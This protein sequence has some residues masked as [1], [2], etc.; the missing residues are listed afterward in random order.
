[1]TKSTLIDLI[2]ILLISNSLVFC[3]YEQQYHVQQANRLNN[4]CIFIGCSCNNDVIKCPSDN[5]EKLGM[6]PKRNIDQLIISRNVSLILKNN[7]LEMIPDDRL[8]YLDIN[9]LD[10]SN[11]RIMKLSSEAFRDVTKV[12]ELN[13]ANNQLRHLN[14]N[15]FRPLEKCLVTLNVENNYFNELDS[16]RFSEVFLKLKELKNLYLANNRLSSLPNLSKLNIVKL[17]AESNFIETLVD[18]FTGHHLLP[19]SLV[20]LN[21]RSNRLKQI[22]DNTF[23][24]LEMLKL[25]NL[26]SNQISALAEN[27]FNHLTNLVWIDL[28]QN[29]LKHIPSRIFY[30]LVNLE[31]LDL[32]SQLIEKIDDYAF[33][34]KSNSKVVQKIDLSNNRISRISNRAFCSKNSRVNYV[35][36]KEIDLSNS[37]LTLVNSCVLRQLAK[38]YN[39]VQSVK[40]A[41]RTRVNPRVVFRATTINATLINHEDETLK[42]KVKLLECNCEL[43]RSN[44][45]VDLEAS[46]R[47]STHNEP[48]KDNNIVQ[49]A[50][51]F[52]CGDYSITN[53]NQLNRYCSLQK[54][55]ECV[56]QT[57]WGE[58]ES[59]SNSNDYLNEHSSTELVQQSTTLSYENSSQNNS[60]YLSL[61]TTLPFNYSNE[62]LNNS[63]WEYYDNN[64]Y[65][66]GNVDNYN[67]EQNAE[68]GNLSG[69]NLTNNTIISVNNICSPSFYSNQ[70]YFN[71]FLFS[72]FLFGI[73]LI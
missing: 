54:Q 37:Q 16:T 46:C 28:R 65:D 12:E 8:A 49:S 52:D 31:Y 38:G 1:M 7:Y 35:N 13:L 32:S 39:D 63:N 66:D 23:E 62:L 42:H 15:V 64:R 72:N 73:L 67:N 2:L 3:A 29:N 60:V 30:S 58:I 17:S 18:S 48:D 61:L 6:F 24:N 59:D 10:L 20:E 22:N 36:L 45:L 14:P 34:R 5:H 21:L 25:L 70:Y 11:N 40:S 71:L 9:K 26:A 4:K 69:T 41:Q 50:K 33:D 55:Y 43:T 19:T 68:A 47:L 27:A 53:L 56:K 44:R 57:Y 51:F